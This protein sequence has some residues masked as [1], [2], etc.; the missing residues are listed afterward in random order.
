MTLGLLSSSCCGN[1]SVLLLLFPPH[2]ALH[3]FSVFSPLASCSPPVSTVRPTEYCT[4]SVTCS[5]LMQEFLSSFLHVLPSSQDCQNNCN[6]KVAPLLSCCCLPLSAHISFYSLF[7]LVM[8]TRRFHLYPT[9]L[10]VCGSMLLWFDS[11][12][13]KNCLWKF[14]SMKVNF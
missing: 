4:S 5:C 8:V 6:L 7:H 9:L 10:S 2:K 14:M 11:V 13:Q 3:G 1:F 12:C